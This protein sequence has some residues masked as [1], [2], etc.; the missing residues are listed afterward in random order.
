MESEK[1]HP[2]G[3]KLDVRVK[4]G[5]RRNVCLCEKTPPATYDP[6]A[7]ELSSP[8][9]AAGSVALA[10]DDMVAKHFKYEKVPDN[11]AKDNW[12]V[13]LIWVSFA[14]CFFIPCVRGYYA[15]KKAESAPVAPAVAGGEGGQPVYAATVVP[16]QGA[17]PVYAATV[18]PQQQQTISVT[19]PPG[20]QP[21]SYL[22][23]RSAW[24]SNFGRPRWRPTSLVDFHIGAVTGRPHRPSRHPARR[25]A[26]RH[27]PGGGAAVNF[28][29]T[30]T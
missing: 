3:G 19:I 18:V 26:R 25:R 6:A 20:A 9:L 16:Q 10:C 21:G 27:G 22:T 1:D 23:V 13:I 14:G 11:W 28:T 2:D 30:C 8:G 4:Y 12:W 15:R 24:K 29:W 7:L 17:Q 5:H